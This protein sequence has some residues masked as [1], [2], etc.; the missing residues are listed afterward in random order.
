MGTSA[1]AGAATSKVSAMA[2]MVPD[3]QLGL[4]LG[5]MQ[6]TDCGE[7]V[8]SEKREGK[9]GG[10]LNGLDTPSTRSSSGGSHRTRLKRTRAPSERRRDLQR[11]FCKFCK[12][13]N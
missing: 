13:E 9:K 5:E 6:P 7:L 4:A 1:A 11:K 10:G 8:R 2:R 12:C 3:P